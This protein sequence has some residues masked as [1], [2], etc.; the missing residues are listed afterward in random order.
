G[1]RPGTVAL[2]GIVLALCAIVVV[3]LAPTGA[4]AR[5]HANTSTVIGLSLV[6]GVLFGAFFICFSRTSE[7]AGL[8]PVVLSRAASGGLLVASA[9]LTLGGLAVRSLIRFVTPMGV[10]ETIAGV[11]LLLALQRGPVATASVLA[12]LY[13]VTTVLLAAGVLRERLS[14]PQLTGVA[15]ALVAVVLVTAS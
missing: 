2:T 5:D 8:W 11:A 7:D 1:E 4:G 13:P 15:L 9:F 12:S 14:R 10:A 6:A 3:S